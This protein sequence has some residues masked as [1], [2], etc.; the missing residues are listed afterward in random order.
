MRGKGTLQTPVILLHLAIRWLPIE[1][2]ELT[3]CLK[4]CL[5][6][7]SIKAK[8]T[9]LPLLFLKKEINIF[10]FYKNSFF[11]FQCL[12]QKFDI[13]HILQ[14]K[15]QASGRP[16]PLGFSK[17]LILEEHI[18]LQNLAHTVW[19]FRHKDYFRR[20]SGLWHYVSV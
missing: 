19:P 10:L 14:M 17:S 6:V 11:N 5:Q 16:H 20:N 12:K 13:L 1:A 3:K 9:N 8:F 2:T 7:F 15:A 4:S 18:S